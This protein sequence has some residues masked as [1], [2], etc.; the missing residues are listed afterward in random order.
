MCTCILRVAAAPDALW[1]RSFF[2]LLRPTVPS[3]P[4]LFRPLY[5]RRMRLK[6]TKDSVTR[7]CWLCVLFSFVYCRT[8]TASARVFSSMRPRWNRGYS[9]PEHNGIVEIVHRRKKNR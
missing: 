7:A 8:E 5:A 1:F 2:S 4:V 6:S 9:R 3:F